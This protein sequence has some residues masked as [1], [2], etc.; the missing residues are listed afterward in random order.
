[1]AVPDLRTLR[2]G[3]VLSGGGA[4]A[5]Y[6]IGCW[7]ALRA[8]GLDRFEAVAG[9]SVGAINAVLV[10]TG[11]LDA[12]EAAWRSLRLRDV[13]G[14]SLRSAPR[15]PLWLLA[16]LGSEF[17]PFKLTRLSDRMGDRRTGWIHPALCAAAGA[18]LWP[19]RGLFPD[20]WGT[21]VALVPPLLGA[22]VLG[23]RIL[24]P[25]FLR[26]VLTSN[27]PLALTLARALDDSDVEALRRAG[28]PVYGVLSRYCPGA[29]GTHRWGGWAPGYVRLDR[30]PDAATLCRLLVQG[31]A[32]PGFLE[33]GRVDG[34][35][36]LDGAWTDNVPLAPLLYGGHHLDAVIVIYLKRIVRHTPR[37]NSL[38]GLLRLLVRD[39]RPWRGTE[40]G[41]ILEWAS[42]RWEACA[43][44]G[45]GL[46]D[47]APPATPGPPHV[48]EIIA[49]APSRRIG[50]FFTG[51][52]W[53][54]RRKSAALIALGERDMREAIERL[55]RS[56]PSGLRGANSS[57]RPPD[58]A[59]AGSPPVPA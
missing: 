8:M 41:G 47:A 31:S 18:G 20:G 27:A 12:A 44:S 40:T 21:G 9:S 42:L 2:V 56:R 57:R 32:L 46:P 58:T 23:H 33:G 54:S 55:A 28:R 59:A 4:K 15:L 11:R 10:G 13:I 14:L 39:A 25:W 19:F 7:K 43:R 6:Q 36:V 34:R 22:L 52:L 51:T 29:P 35:L 24:R 3:L 17:S 37:H 53:F 1:M 38:W 45:S 30:V 16:G 26:P 5:A 48:P 49:V 50:N